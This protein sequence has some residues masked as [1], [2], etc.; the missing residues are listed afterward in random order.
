MEDWTTAISPACH[1]AS[2]VAL[3]LFELAAATGELRFREAAER[4]FEYEQ[5]YFSSRHN[6]WPDFR[7]LMLNTP[8]AQWTTR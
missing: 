8:E 7:E 6:N 4:G 3:A 5:Q 1:G 2:G